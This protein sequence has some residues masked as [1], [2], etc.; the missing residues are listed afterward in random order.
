MFP[1][2]I[3]DCRQGQRNWTR[4]GEPPLTPIFTKKLDKNTVRRRE[5]SRNLLVSG[6]LGK[7]LQQFQLKPGGMPDNQ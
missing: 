1:Y 3:V 4:T 2:W 5:A 7:V 6:R